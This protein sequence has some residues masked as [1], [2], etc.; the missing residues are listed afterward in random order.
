MHTRLL[1]QVVTIE[2]DDAYMLQHQPTDLMLALSLS[3]NT[4]EVQHV[5]LDIP[6]PILEPAHTHTHTRLSR[7]ETR[8]STRAYTGHCILTSRKE[9]PFGLGP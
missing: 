9:I 4:L 3:L 5:M 8:K 2:S 1:R 6:L 7:D